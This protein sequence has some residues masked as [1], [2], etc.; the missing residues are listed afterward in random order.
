M[1][2]PPSVVAA[3]TLFGWNEEELCSWSLRALLQ[4]SKA[5]SIVLNQSMEEEEEELH[6]QS[7]VKEDC[8]EITN[9]CAS[10]FK[11]N[12]VSVFSF[13]YT[14]PPEVCFLKKFF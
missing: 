5:Q 8:T 10:T 13:P 14:I 1:A 6:G 11:T 12:G 3:D 2:V 9:E 4:V 7:E